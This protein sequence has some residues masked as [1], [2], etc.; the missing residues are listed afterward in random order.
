MGEKKKKIIRAVTV[1]MSFTFLKGVMKELNQKYEMVALSSAGPE[2]QELAESDGVRCIT[3]EMARHISLK[4]DVKSL[5]QM[6]KT[7]RR[8]KPYMVHSMTPKAGL[9]SMIAAWLCGVPVRVHTFTGLVFPTST[10]LK[11]R[12]L[13]F[14]DWLTCACATH[15]IAEGQGVKNDLVNNGI[16]KKNVRVLGYGNVKGIDLNVYSRSEEV[17][18][19]AEELRSDKFTF[20]TVGRVVGDKGINEM[21]AA[22]K[23]LNGEYPDTRLV[24]VGGYEETLDPVKSETKAEIDSNDAIEAVGAMKDVRPWYAASDVYIS[25]SYREGFPNTVIEAGAMGLPCVVTDINGSREII[26]DGE[27]GVIIPSKSE[28]ALYESMK[29]IYINNVE[30]ER[31]AKNARPMIASR[32]EQSFVRQCLYDFYDE[33]MK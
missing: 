12:I 16:T 18:S 28:D 7:L 26:H 8:E 30:R 33:V 2:Q 31:M 22:F 20:L 32:Y 14:T 15:V 27:N 9:I 29:R 23:R 10:G 5:C 3:L 21:V 11:R 19:R 17:M 25:A 13:M 4:Q 1:S 6:I 24:L